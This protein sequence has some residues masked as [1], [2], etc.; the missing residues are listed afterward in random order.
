MKRFLK[1]TLGVVFLAFALV[2]VLAASRSA[3]RGH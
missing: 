1:L 3:K 2:V